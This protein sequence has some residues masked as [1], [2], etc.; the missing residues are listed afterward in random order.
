MDFDAYDI[1]IVPLIV[2][3]VALAT[4]FG[5][6]KRFAPLLSLALGLVAAFVYISPGNIPQAILSG[7]TLG[8]S[9]VGLYS[10][11]K[12]TFLNSGGKEQTTQNNGKD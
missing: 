6:P 2:G 8:L 4:S 12:N 10:G 11:S 1:A 5:L 9:A 3:L 7:I